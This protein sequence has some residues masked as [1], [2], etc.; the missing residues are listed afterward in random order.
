MVLDAIWFCLTPYYSF[1]ISWK[2][3]LTQ[4][5]KNR[6]EEHFNNA[7]PSSINSLF[8]R[9]ILQRHLRKFVSAEMWCKGST[10]N[11]ILG[12]AAFYIPISWV[13]KVHGGCR[14]FF[15][16]YSQTSNVIL[17]P[18]TIFALVENDE[19]KK[20]MINDYFLSFKIQMFWEIF[21][22]NINY[23]CFL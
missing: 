1:D 7:F 12:N 4:G 20:N 17:C 13:N 11:K 3:N 19:Q 16:G 14:I 23:F 8:E 22:I 6:H 18:L 10:G 21:K 5:K 15:D 2:C 9:G